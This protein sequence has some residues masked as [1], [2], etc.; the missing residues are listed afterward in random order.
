MKRQSSIVALCI[1]SESEIAKVMPTYNKD[2]PID[3]PGPFKEMMHALGMDVSRP[4]ERQDGLWHRN[5]LNEIVLCSRY[6]G[7]ERQDAEWL[8]SGYASQSA[9]DKASGSRMLEDM[10]RAR[11]LTEDRQAALAD[12][13]RYTVTTEE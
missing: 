10:Y 13:E 9:K 7:H 11:N 1:I 6:V 3:F 4:I 12:R 2:Y 8:T 5:R